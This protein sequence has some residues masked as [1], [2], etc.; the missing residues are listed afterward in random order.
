MR[1]TW[2]Y[3]VE[4]YKYEDKGGSSKNVQS[5]VDSA[6]WYFSLGKV[7]KYRGKTQNTVLH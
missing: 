3:L 6:D 2:L 7:N 5:M 4:L 1:R